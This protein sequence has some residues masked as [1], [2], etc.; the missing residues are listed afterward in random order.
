M[1]TFLN[2]IEAFITLQ[3]FRINEKN[4]RKQPLKIKLYHYHFALILILVAYISIFN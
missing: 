3:F 1:R 4:F 2:F